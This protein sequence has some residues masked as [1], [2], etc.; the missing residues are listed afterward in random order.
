MIVEIVCKVHSPSPNI[1]I[2]AVYHEGQKIEAQE[3]KPIL[4]I[5]WVIILPWCLYENIWI[6]L[7]NNNKNHYKDS[8]FD[9][10]SYR[11]QTSSS[12]EQHFVSEI[13]TLVVNIPFRSESLRNYSCM[14]IDPKTEIILHQDSVR[15]ILYHSKLS[16]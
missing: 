10:F 8:R 12:S 13:Q 1:A 2:P 4:D 15:M 6:L 3:W 7:Y 14:A 16:K 9:L 11:N 5:Q